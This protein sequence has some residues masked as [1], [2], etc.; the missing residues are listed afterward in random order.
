M[1]RLLFPLSVALALIPL[2]AQTQSKKGT[3]T[4]NTKARLSNEA[5]DL[6][7]ATNEARTAIQARNKEDAI[8]HIDHALAQAMLLNASNLRYIPLYDEWESY[9]VIGPL[10]NQRNRAH[11][12]TATPGTNADNSTA[13]SNARTKRS[14]EIVEEASREYTSVALDVQGAK[15]HL[16]AAQQAVNKGAFREADAALAAVQDGVVVASVAADLP[17]LK[18]RENMVLARDAADRDHYHEA[19][20]ALQAASEALNQYSNEQN[21]HGADARAL[22]EEIDT[23]NQT[24]EQNH[25]DASTKIEEWWDRMADWVAIPNQPRR[26]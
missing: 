12:Q 6:L 3:T 2:Q 7:N 1:L 25:A 13:N 9:S 21:P 4:T 10:M 15:D 23:Y 19:H 24:I 14:N 26:G 11:P 5:S 22:R 18:A 20:A 16:Q 17:L 8:F